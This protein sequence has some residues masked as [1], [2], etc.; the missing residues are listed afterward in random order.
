LIFFWIFRVLFLNIGPLPPIIPKTYKVM[1]VA[2]NQSARKII[3][4]KES[5]LK[6]ARGSAKKNTKK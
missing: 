2:N 3:D 5:D 6:S 4:K 1:E